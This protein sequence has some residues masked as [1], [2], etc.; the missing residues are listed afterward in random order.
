MTTRLPVLQRSEPLRPETIL[1]FG[2]GRFLRAFADFFVDRANRSG[3]YNGH[4]VVVQ[5]TGSS[6][7][8]LLNRQDGCY[9]L[10][11]RDEGKQSFETIQS[12]SRAVSARQDWGAVLSLAR[13]LD[14]Q[15]VLSNTTEVGLSLDED[16]THLGSP[17]RSFPAKLTAV[18]YERA[19]H[20]DFDPARGLVVLPCELVENNG[21]LLRSLVQD[22]AQR[23]RLGDAFSAWLDESTAFCNTLVDRIVP[24][25]PPEDKY[26]AA[27]QELGYQDSLLI[28]AESYRLWAIEGDASIMERI[29]FVDADPGII[30]ADDITPYRLRKVRL[31]NGGH[32]LSVPLGLLAGNRTV[33]DNMTSAVTGP[34]I[35]ALL[36]DEIGPVLD[37][38][39][40]TVEPYIDEVLQRWRNPFLVHRLIDITL[41]STT[42]MRHRVVPSI[43]D[44]YAL[45]GAAPRHMALGF[46]AYLLFMNG[47]R[48]PDGTFVGNWL[49]WEYPIRDS[50]AAALLGYWQASES[51]PDLVSAVSKDERLWGTNLAALPGWADAVAA[52]LTLLREQ[53]ASAAVGHL[54]R[55]LS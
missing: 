27:E 5:S 32:T 25:T 35:R 28:T 31:L 48:A 53:G 41:E 14:L 51:V 44:Y 54:Q 50:E 16:E 21:D 18:L 42:K 23:A 11:T 13:S 34:Y 55:S 3:Q 45:H 4:I 52:F 20:F 19:R 1:Q 39:P 2:T 29:G 47:Q 15:V 10:W 26:R 7:A 37:V 36:R 9:T 12:I 24:G 38:D 46:A 6:Q 30:V 40:A 17:P 33:L 8:A 49:G 43:E 22:V